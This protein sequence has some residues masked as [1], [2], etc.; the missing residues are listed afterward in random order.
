MAE[1][2]NKASIL[3]KTLRELT[4]SKELVDLIQREISAER[5]YTDGQVAVLVQR[6]DDAD[7]AT[8]L[9]S[10]TV[11]RTPTEIQKQIGHLRELTGEKFVSVNTRFTEIKEATHIALT[12]QKDSLGKAEMNTKESLTKLENLFTA[13]TDSMSA[14][15]SDIKSDVARINNLK[16]GGEQNLGKIYAAIGAMGVILGILVL[17]S[18]NVF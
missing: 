16:L 2:N 5:D 4:N 1:D 6:M 10:E 18:N 11:N 8:E 14:S 3:D 15:M 13:K 7:K 12:S 17:L 9:L